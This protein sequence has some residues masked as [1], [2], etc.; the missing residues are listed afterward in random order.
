MTDKRIPK[1][2]RAN[3]HITGSSTGAYYLYKCEE[4]T[5]TCTHH[6]RMNEDKEDLPKNCLKG[7]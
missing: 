4:C 3:G 2:K 7:G 6:L 1:W 5:D